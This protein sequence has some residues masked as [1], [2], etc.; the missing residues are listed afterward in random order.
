MT[1]GCTLPN[2]LL[3]GS[4][5]VWIGS[6]MNHAW[7]LMMFWISFHGAF[8]SWRS[9]VVSISSSARSMRASSRRRRLLLPDEPVVRLARRAPDILAAERR[10]RH[11]ALKPEHNGL[12]LKVVVML[13]MSVL[14]SIGVSVILTPTFARSSRMKLAMLTR[15]ALLLLVFSMKLTGLPR[16]S[17]SNAV[18]VRLLESDAG[19]QLL[20]FGR[21]VIV[22]DEIGRVPLLVAA[23]RLRPILLAVAVKRTLDER[24]AID[25]HRHGAAEVPIVEPLRT[26]PDRRT[27]PRDV[28]RASASRREWA[29]ALCSG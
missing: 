29:A 17:S 13:V 19:E 25:R 23:R 9:C 18:A 1:L 26:S 10:R 15:S 8:C 16:A 6:Q 22:L 11:A 27:A 2:R 28:C 4:L 14:K 3:T 12:V 24:V 20:R 21:V 5:I 7:S